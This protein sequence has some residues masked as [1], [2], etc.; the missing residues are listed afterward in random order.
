MGV[1]GG[2]SLRGT[3]LDAP[4]GLRC[5]GEASP[6][7]FLPLLVDPHG[8]MALEL[9]GALGVHTSGFGRGA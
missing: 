6:S 7:P 1:N 9:S 8:P 4:R 3:F 2:V 5:R